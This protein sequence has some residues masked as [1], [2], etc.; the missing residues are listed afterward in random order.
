MTEA[1]TMLAEDMAAFYADPLRFVRYTFPWGEGDLAEWTGPDE[2]QTEF[3]TSVGDAVRNRVDDEPVK[4]AVKTGRGPGKTA[5]EAWLILWLMST[6]PNFAGF[7]TAN[8]GDQLDD[9]LWRELAL[10]WNRAINKHW[11]QWTATRFYQIDAKNT[12][13]VD[14]LKWSENNPDALGGLHNGGRGQCAIVDEGSGVPGSIYDVIDAT[15][16]DPDSFVFVF[17]NPMRRTGRFAELFGRFSHRWKTMTVDCRRAKAPNQAK[18]AQDIEDWGLDSDYIRVN[19][20]GEF[21]KADVDTLIAQPLLDGAAK[22]AASGMERVRPIWG[23][24]VAR[25]GDDR[26]A[27]AIR[28]GRKLMKPVESW[29]GLDTMQTA[30]KI[31]ALWTETPT[32][33][34]PSRILVDVIGIGAGV[35][36]RLRELD[37]PVRGVNVSESPSVDGKFHKLRDELWW[38]ARVFFEGLACEVVDQSLAAE[39]AVVQYSFTSSG[40]IRVEPKH[41]T[42]DRLGRSPD[43]A[44][45]F[46]LTFAEMDQEI[47]TDRRD[48]YSRARERA[49]GDS[50]S[51][52]AA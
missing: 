6:R 5:V 52:W 20:L 1:D 19:V 8:T 9:K 26:S 39:L 2:W 27:L 21:P 35:V 12:W 28:R 4:V 50:G 16:T 33:E 41:D 13:G 11:F 44:D 38:K 30:G 48:R 7:A 46:V 47:E 18:I 25:F 3:L 17:G 31:M 42:K 45:A 49:W 23:L 34:R 37:L 10:W 36:D 32:D 51:A 29:R 22:R 14:A 15:M 40:L 24:D 43:L